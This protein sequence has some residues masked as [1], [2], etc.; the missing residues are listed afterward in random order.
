MA[1]MVG[2]GCG[3]KL[4]GDM[5]LVT[6]LERKMNNEEQHGELKK[7][8]CVKMKTHTHKVIDKR[9]ILRKRV[10]NK[11]IIYNKSRL[12]YKCKSL[13]RIKLFQAHKKRPRNWN[14]KTWTRWFRFH[15]EKKGR[16]KRQHERECM[17]SKN[18]NMSVM[19]L[20]KRQNYQVWYSCHVL[21]R[22]FCLRCS[23]A[24]YLLK[25]KKWHA[26]YNYKNKHKASCKGHMFRHKHK[27]KFKSLCDVRRDRL[28]KRRH[29]RVMNS[30]ILEYKL[31]QYST[32]MKQLKVKHKWRFKEGFD[33]TFFGL[34]LRTSLVYWGKV[35]TLSYCLLMDLMIC[36]LLHHLFD[37]IWLRTMWRKQ[38]VKHKFR[39]KHKKKF[40]GENN[41]D[42]PWGC[43]TWLL[44][45]S[46]RKKV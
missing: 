41:G 46:Q 14:C 24:K 25:R 36:L 7:K 27:K 40:E 34:S 8:T 16:T 44:R 21:N 6:A 42:C 19:K 22:G 26:K 39:H 3:F 30:W 28:S 45:V 15:K 17:K 18:Q 12:K 9:F 32:A 23:K 31:R 13:N 5:V 33:N 10:T 43:R 11:K 4:K 2:S 38:R 1:E 29:K 35:Y 20:C 37:D